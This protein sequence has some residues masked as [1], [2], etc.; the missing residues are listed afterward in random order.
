MP[1]T[2]T[3]PLAIQVFRALAGAM[4]PMLNGLG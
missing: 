1:K 4:E 2:S 3:K